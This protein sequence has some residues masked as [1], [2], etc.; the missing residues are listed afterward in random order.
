[1]VVTVTTNSLFGVFLDVLA[2]FQG[3][4]QSWEF[5]GGILAS[6]KLIE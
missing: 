1:M 3:I 4:E 5:W 6:R 2:G